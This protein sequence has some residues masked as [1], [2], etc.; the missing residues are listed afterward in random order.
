MHARSGYLC[1]T[2][3]SLIETNYIDLLRNC[4]RFVSRA[5]AVASPIKFKPWKLRK[6][7]A[8]P[9]WRRL[10]GKHCLREW[11]R[12]YSPGRKHFDSQNGMHTILF[13]CSSYLLL[14][15]KRNGAI[16]S[17]YSIWSCLILEI[18]QVNFFLES[19][20]ARG[21]YA[22]VWVSNRWEQALNPFWS[23]RN[24]L[25]RKNT[26]TTAHGHYFTILFGFSSSFL[27]FCGTC[28]RQIK[29]SSCLAGE[30]FSFSLS[31]ACSSLAGLADLTVAGELRSTL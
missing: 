6:C 3:Y 11:N 12:D 16:F 23:S 17:P 10:R 5:L 13:S 2:S 24:V 22:Y 14:C 30:T 19:K 29:A 31:C 27:C 15:E 21:A 7:I 20:M 1:Q 18:A 9:S 25:S 28:I 26:R 4:N 8:R